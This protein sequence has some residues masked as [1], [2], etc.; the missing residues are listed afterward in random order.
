MNA[1]SPREPFAVRQISEHPA[2]VPPRGVRIGNR[3]MVSG[4]VALISGVII[5]LS[6]N[7][8]N[9]AGPDLAHLLGALEQPLIACGQVLVVGGAV[10]ARL[11]RRRADKNTG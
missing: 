2:A 6:G 4:V 3:A 8:V 7:L 10:V 5:E 1:I 11:A 9:A